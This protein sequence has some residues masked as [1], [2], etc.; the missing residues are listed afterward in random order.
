MLSMST[1]VHTHPLMKGKK[2][3]KQCIYNGTLERIRVMFT[4]PRLSQQPD[5]KSLEESAL[6]AI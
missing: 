4:P 5:T 2:Q 3:D 6:M 1:C